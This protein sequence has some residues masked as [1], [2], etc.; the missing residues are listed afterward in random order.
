MLNILKRGDRHLLSQFRV[1]MIVD[2]VIAV[3][4]ER[5]SSILIEP[6][7]IRAVMPRVS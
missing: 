2:I 7:E 1:T 3:V 5:L 6:V 4:A